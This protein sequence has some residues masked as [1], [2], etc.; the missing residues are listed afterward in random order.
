MLDILG[1]LLMGFFA[2]IGFAGLLHAP[3]RSWIPASL[4]G[5]AGYVVYWLLLRAGWDDP[6]AIFIGSCIASLLAQMTARRLRMIASI[7]SILAII[8]FVPGYGLYQTMFHIGQGDLSQGLAKGVETMSG[9]LMLALGIIVG[10]F[11]FRLFQI[12]KKA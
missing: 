9:I 6:S 12:R 11:V 7:F 10:S 4:I 1:A 3:W 8:P 5:A 2:T